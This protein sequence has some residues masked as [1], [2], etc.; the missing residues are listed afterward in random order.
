MFGRL[1]AFVGL[2]LVLVSQSARAADDPVLT[3]RGGDVVRTVTRSALLADPAL[4]TIAVPD[5]HYAGRVVDYAAIRFDRLIA[6]IPL[7]ADATIKFVATDGFVAVIP[8]GRLLAEGPGARAVPWLA[9]EPPGQPWD[10]K[11]SDAPEIT[12]GPFYLVWE[13]PQASRVQPEEWPYA[14]A[15]IAVGD[16]LAVL[17]PRILPD[18]A[19]AADAP[20]R[21]GFAIF[22]T[23]CLACHTMNRQG[24]ATVGPDLNLPLSPTEYYRPGM[25]AK[26]IADPQ[27]LRRWPNARMTGF[28]DVLSPAQIDDVVAYLAHMAGRKAD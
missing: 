15:E 25:V 13:N 11:R 16:S 28:A 7:P 1:A 2:A 6:G 22:A 17:Y 26:L 10:S 3:I 23:N 12:G 5:P 9:V 27:T 20:A 8:A 19:L 21:R 18:P 24:E 4:T 14:V